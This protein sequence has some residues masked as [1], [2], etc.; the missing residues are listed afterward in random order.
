[1]DGALQQASGETPAAVRLEGQAPFFQAFS[2]RLGSGETALLCSSALVERP[3]RRCRPPFETPRLIPRPG[4]GCCVSP[5]GL[6]GQTRGGCAR[7]VTGRIACHEEM[8]ASRLVV[9]GLCFNC[10]CSRNSNSDTSNE[11]DGHRGLQELP[12]VG[13][14]RR[15]LH[16]HVYGS[17]LGSGLQRDRPPGHEH[18]SFSGWYSGGRPM[19]PGARRRHTRD[20][21]RS[22]WHRDGYLHW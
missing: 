17:E 4:T 1:M 3:P 2:R 19:P 22:E 9:S 12:S 7:V 16:V 21:A 20:D 8:G 13:S 14:P 6:R 18:G 10:F 11:H 15:P 5:M